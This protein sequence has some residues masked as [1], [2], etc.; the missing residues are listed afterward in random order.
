MDHFQIIICVFLLLLLGNMLQNLRMLKDQESLRSE[1]PLPLISVLLPARNEEK[2]IQRCIHS[3][4]GQDYPRLEI[5]VLD[6]NSTD[7][8]YEIMK[9]ISRKFAEI[10]IIKGEK[11]PPG[12]NGKNWACHQLSRVAR[13]DWLLFTDADTT[14]KPH[15]VS[16]AFAAVQRNQSVFLT[17]I[18]G[19]IAKTWSEKLYMPIIH[20]AFF[21]LLPFKLVN[22]SK[23][24]RVPLGIGPFMLIEKVFYFSFG[25]HEALKR[26]I[27][28]DMALAK[29]VKEK[30]GKISVI[31]G[32][33]N[34]NVRFYTCF[35]DVWNGFSKNSYEAIGGHPH[36]VAG[37][38][39]ICYF[40]FIYPYLALWGAFE[41]HQGYALPLFQVM[42]ISLMKIILALKFNTSIFFGLL[43]PLSVL[44]ALLILFNSCRLSMF[45]KK[46]EWKERLY[47]VE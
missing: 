34:M 2:N 5:L 12:W 33:D 28:D 23:N 25:G 18:P 7:R 16:A 31:D 24:S 6:D 37:I 47:P 39:L 3:L 46:F 9:R 17:Y 20:F 36:Y 8:T 29:A 14:H 15:S 13:G 19:L 40:L 43:H 1:K 21:V 44:F 32:T 27:V 45:G 30:G 38:F 35:R 26:A 10:K 11:L 4:L 42:T 22:Y 41:S